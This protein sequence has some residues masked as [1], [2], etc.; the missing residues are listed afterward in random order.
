[1]KRLPSRLLLFA[2]ALLLVLP[3]A[4][5]RPQV[6]LEGGGQTLTLKAPSFVSGAEAASSY[7]G[8][9]LDNEAGISAYYKADILITL[10][11]VRGQFRTIE[12][13]NQDFIIG[14][15]AVP[16]YLEH[17]DVHVY[18]HKDGWILAY[19]LKTDPI[20]KII[21]LKAQT[22]ETTK[23][24]TVVAAVAG[25]AGAAFTDVTYYDF[26]NPNATHILMVAENQAGGNDFTITMP[27]EYGYLERGW[28]LIGAS[29]HTFS[30]NGANVFG[31]GKWIG[32]GM[33]YG[34]LT[35]SQLLPGTTHTIAV[36]GGYSYSW[37]YGVLV[38]LYRV[39]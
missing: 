11:Q 18:V 21:D 25:A 28:G 7:I 1:M 3:A 23:L 31:S 19:Y 14:S 2:L 17:F 8:Q 13:E 34:T 22:I 5:G 4:F 29:G 37:A 35:A 39:P 26:R 33:G 9:R 24:K 27:T 16:N 32:D 36:S 38:I 30:V 15:V 12:V 20:S 10:S 6:K